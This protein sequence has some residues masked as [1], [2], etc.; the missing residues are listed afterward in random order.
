MESSLHQF[1]FAIKGIIDNVSLV[2]QTRIAH[3]D[4]LA[5]AY[6]SPLSEDPWVPSLV[7]T[8][9]ELRQLWAQRP[10]PGN[11]EPPSPAASSPPGAFRK[12]F[13]PVLDRRLGEVD[14]YLH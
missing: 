1:R 8:A 12:D 10:T 7:D 14:C 4:V 9:E 13:N 6:Q 2:G 11:S 5:L 3:Y